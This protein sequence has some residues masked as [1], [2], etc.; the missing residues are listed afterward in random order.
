MFLM[1]PTAS[2]KTDA[3]LRLADAFDV[4]LVNVDSAQIY[5]GMDIGTAKPDRQTL[6]KYPHALIDIL[7]PSQ[8]YSAAGFRQDALQ[9]I[10]KAHRLGKLPLLVGGT[11]LYFRALEHG[12]TELPQAS[13]AIRDAI[14]NEAGSKGWPAMHA[15][16]Q[17]IDPAAAARID[18]NDPQRIQR[19]LEVYRASGRSLSEWWQ[20]DA[21]QGSLQS[22]LLKVAFAPQDRELRRKRIE[23]RFH[24]MM[25]K[26]FLEEVRQLHARGDLGTGMPSMRAVGYRQL[27]AHLE[28]LVSLEEAIRLGIVASRQYAKRQMTWLRREQQV[29]WVDALEPGAMDALVRRVGRFLEGAV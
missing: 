27:W 29:D 4:H 24:D 12:L 13:G 3:A 10:E 7:E 18:S 19:A 5:R 8:S 2:G 11:G 22:R 23:D 17:S 20:S 1:G 15:E 16:L 26:G 14:R 28:G 9:E 25:R 6:E 21:Q